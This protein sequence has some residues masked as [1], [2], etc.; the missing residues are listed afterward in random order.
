MKRHETTW[1]TMAVP[2][3]HKRAKRDTDEKTEIA[4]FGS[5]GKRNAA[6]LE[7]LKIWFKLIDTD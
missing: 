5:V 3:T 1:G 6:K 2:E 7:F 4:V